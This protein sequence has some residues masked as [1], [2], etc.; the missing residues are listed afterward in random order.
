MAFLTEPLI[1]GNEWYLSILG[2]HPEQ[3][4]KGL[5]QKLLTPVLEE[6]DKQGLD[7]FLET[8]TPRNMSFYE[9]LGYQ[10]E[11]VFSEQ[12]TA[13]DYAVMVRTAN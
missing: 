7:T 9:R 3:Q 11:K 10:S 2:I 12:V 8:F 1:N 6:A 13:S 4:N 5:G